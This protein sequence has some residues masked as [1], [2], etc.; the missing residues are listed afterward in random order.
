MSKPYIPFHIPCRQ[1]TS[2]ECRVLEDYLLRDI[3]A[4][5]ERAAAERP[6]DAGSD[7]PIMELEVASHEVFSLSLESIIV[8]FD[9]RYFQTSS[10]VPTHDITQQFAKVMC[11]FWKGC[12]DNADLFIWEHDGTFHRLVS[13]YSPEKRLQAR[14]WYTR[15]HWL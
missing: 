11:V 13:K 12:P 8:V 3:T 14:E 1:A 15:N 5:N 6:V 10:L 2:E 7:D 4:E 9:W